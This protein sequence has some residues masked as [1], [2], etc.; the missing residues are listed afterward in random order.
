MG[1]VLFADG[2]WR[3]SGRGRRG[4]SAEAKFRRAKELI[5]LQE[6]GEFVEPEDL[7]WLEIYRTTPEFRAQELM[8]EEFGASMWTS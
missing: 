8:F 4:E 1:R 6:A 5:D 2:G 3:R 7:A